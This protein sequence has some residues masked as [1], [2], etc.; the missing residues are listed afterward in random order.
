[1]QQKTQLKHRSNP[2]HTLTLERQYESRLV[3]LFR[4]FKRDA[5]NL[6]KQSRTLERD[7]NESKLNMRWFY[8]QIARLGMSLVTQGKQV[9][10][11]QTQ[12]NYQAG[13]IYGN[14]ALKR[15]GV[16]V[17][18]GQGPADWRVID[19]LQVTNLSALKGITE[20]MNKQIIRELIDGVQKGE[21]IVKLSKR[22]TDRVDKIGI[23]RARAMA[24][25]ETV[26]AFV[27]GAE[28]RYTRAGIETLEWLTAR[29]ERVCPI[30]APLDGKRFAV[31]SNHPRPAIHVNCRCDIL[32]VL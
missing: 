30:C 1:M 32:P 13:T 29:D 6:L 3:R 7:L 4:I 24:R 9:T 20:E 14:L 22:I 31:K 15:I 23:T 18:I 25:T 26:N 2:S 11:E 8:D 27:R 21:G 16:E 12:K 10:D 17:A 5:I 28:L 19:A